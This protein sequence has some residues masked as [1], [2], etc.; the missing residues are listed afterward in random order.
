MAGQLDAV[1]IRLL[2]YDEG[3]Y[4]KVWFNPKEYTIIRREV[5][6]R[7]NNSIVT[8]FFDDYIEINGTRFPMF[9]DV[10]TDRMHLNIRYTKV[11][12]NGNVDDEL[13]SLSEIQE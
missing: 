12:V 6:N 9:V 2:Y 3:A 1:I 11:E 4:H 5:Y 7:D 10:K 13:F 8:I